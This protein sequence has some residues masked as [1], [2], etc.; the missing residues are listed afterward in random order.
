MAA[1]ADVSTTARDLGLVETRRVVLYDRDDPLVL[2]SGR[3]LAPVEVAYETYGTLNAD[4]SNAV[5]ICHA[6][7]GDA[8]A[9]GHH[10]DPSRRGWW[11]TLI[12]PGKAVDTDRFFVVC[13]NLLGGCKGT[14]G[15]RS[16]DPATGRRY[17]MSFP[18]ITISDLVAV[19][20]RLLHHLGVRQLHAAIGGSLGGMQVLQWLL[21]WPGEI[22][23][24]VMVC[25]TSA[26][27]AQNIA[28]ST[29]ARSAILRD[30]AFRGGE[31]EDGEGPDVGLA[32]AR[33]IGHITY[34]SEQG[35]AEKFGRDRRDGRTDARLEDADT[36]LGTAFEVESYLY[37]QASS[38]L[39]RFDAL[40]YLWLTR[41]MDFFEP[42]S[43]P[44]RV[45][46]AL[47]RQPDMRALVLSFESDWRFPTAHSVRLAEGLREG[48]A[49][50]VELREIPSTYGH[51]SFLL[52]VPGYQEAVAAF[53]ADAP[54]P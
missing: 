45:R 1:G 18:P 30:P 3:T 19:Q 16:I 48:G 17:G 47:A 4:A 15:P 43:E 29:A 20:R 54:L 27:S 35:M 7:T 24:A 22:E 28:L 38:F 6:L 31:Y 36:W 46:A 39:R 5:V 40:S 51:D 49:R 52:R 25:A 33:M 8:H 44:E 34:L 50:H 41:V 11:D 23:R 32:V 12:G 53:L 9:A 37:H 21:D 13:S 26:L 14:T 10:G 2:S 42:F